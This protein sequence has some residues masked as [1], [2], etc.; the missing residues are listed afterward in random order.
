MR[1]ILYTDT[2]NIFQ[3]LEKVCNWTTFLF[4]SKTA[5]QLVERIKSRLSPSRTK[6][7]ESSFSLFLRLLAAHLTKSK[8]K[9]TPAQK[10]C[11]RIFIKFPQ[12]EKL[13]ELSD[14]GINN[15]ATLLLTIALLN[16]LEGTVSV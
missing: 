2:K 3:N 11:G 8:A 7:E 9:N 10:L 12:S 1:S 5:S 16:D 13:Q 15:W 6:E 4:S 14:A